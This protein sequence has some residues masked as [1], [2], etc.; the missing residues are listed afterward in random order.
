MSSTL[1]PP[2]AST[3]D[4]AVAV[5]VD[6]RPR[7]LL[8]GWVRFL[9]G[10]FSLYRTPGLRFAK[11]LGSGH[12]GGFGLRPS[13][14]RQGLFCVFADS[15]SADAFIASRWLHEFDTRAREWCWLKLEAFSSRGRWSGCEISVGTPT[16]L[17]GPVVSLTRASIRWTRAVRF[18]RHAPAAESALAG[19][20]GCSLAVG[21][22]EA[23]VL[24]QATLS[25]WDSVE[26]M[27]AYARSGAHQKA[28]AAAYQG[29]HFSE[30][31]FV[32]WRLLAQGG[33]WKGIRRA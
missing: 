24:R 15:E 4:T 33:T 25:V 1:A 19:A 2:R 9:W 18:W 21:L 3:G 20:G 10:R 23:P 7:G 30:S 8:W 12:D 32:R 14:S 11:V 27:D 22:G 6:L 17:Q 5:L 29:E 31:M 13:F 28:I 26:A 16:P